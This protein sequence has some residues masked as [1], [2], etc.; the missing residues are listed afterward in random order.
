[1]TFKSLVGIDVIIVT[2]HGGGSQVINAITELLF[3]PSS[4]LESDKKL[5]F[6][7]GMK[8]LGGAFSQWCSLD[9][10]S[11]TFTLGVLSA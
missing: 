1:M 4:R 9:C 11:E 8:V 3:L 6:D 2:L 7:L 5:S 10:D